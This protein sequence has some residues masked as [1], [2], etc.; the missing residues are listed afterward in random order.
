M[1][2]PQVITAQRVQVTITVTDPDRP[3]RPPFT[4][5]LYF[6]QGQ[7]PNNATIRQLAVDRYQAW[8]QA[9]DTRPPRPPRA[10]RLRALREARDAAVAQAAAAEAELAAEQAS[11]DI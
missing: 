6:D 10:E 8:R 1:A 2:P 9:V 4:D 7:V 11:T 3:D 5:A